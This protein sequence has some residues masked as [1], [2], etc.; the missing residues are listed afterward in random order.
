MMDKLSNLPSAIADI[1][2]NEDSVV[3]GACLEGNIPFCATYEL[4]RQG[5]RN[6]T[7]I[8]PISDASTDMLIGAGCVA[9]LAGAWVPQHFVRYWGRADNA[10]FWPAMVCPLMTHIDR[11]PFHI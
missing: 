2:R 9:G 5:K 1:V 6:L 4:I 3:L 11:P 10:G 7:M 8:A